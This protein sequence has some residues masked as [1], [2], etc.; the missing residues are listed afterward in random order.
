MLPLQECAF[1]R[2]GSLFHVFLFL[3]GSV[4]TH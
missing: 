3:R 2:S 4:L 1:T